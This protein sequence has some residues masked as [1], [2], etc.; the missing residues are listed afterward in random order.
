VGLISPTD[1]A[2]YNDS[3]TLIPYD[4]AGAEA[5][6][7]RAGWLRGAQGWTRGGAAKPS[8]HLVLRYRPD[9]SVFETIAL[10]F[11]EAASR[12]GIPVELRPTESGALNG[13]LHTGDF[14][15]YLRTLKGNPFAFN[16]A[17]ILHSKA[18]GEGN[19]TGFGTPA[20]DKL[21]EAVAAADSPAHQARLLRRFQALMQEQMPLVPLFFLPTRLAASRQL[22][23][24][25]AFDL[26]PG[27]VATTLSWLP[28]PPPLAAH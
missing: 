14:D 6:L 15:V 12:L 3:L 16:F 26:K 4:V 8:L 7:R 13:A 5:L 27:Y 19:L 28:E 10:Q 20:S 2:R 23:G 21:I 25:Q 18:V 11:R 24:V 1:K 9:E 17:P 22:A